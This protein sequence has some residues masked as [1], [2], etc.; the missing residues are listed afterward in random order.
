MIALLHALEEFFRKHLFVYVSGNIFL[1]YLDEKNK[2][3]SVSPDIFVVFGVEKKD[4]RVYKLEEEGVAPQVVIELTSAS[5]K[6]EDLVKKYYT[7]ARMGVREY[8]L[9]DPY[10][11][12]TQT[13]LS[14][15]RLEGGEYT[16]LHG[17]SLHS[18]VLGLE[19]R[20]EDNLLRLY[21]PES[22][23]CLRSP[24]ETEDELR[25]LNEE[26]RAE[27][28]LRQV[29]EADVEAAEAKLAQE[30]AARQAAEAQAA[31]ELAARQA[32]EA[33]AAQELAAR[34]AAEAQAAQELAARQAA[35]AQAAAAATEITRLREELAKRSGKNL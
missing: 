32:A 23:E 22:G 13:M 24:Q 21:N 11:E 34:Q 14:G 5:T 19:L 35:E 15:F 25:H 1:Y 7:Y 31:Q 4:R 12:D 26:F 33:Q 9:F 28:A 17:T 6:E 30:L 27:R 8:F 16:P 2:I 20:V 29:A 3:Q 18:D 10:S